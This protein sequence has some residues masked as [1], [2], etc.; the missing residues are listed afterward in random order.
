MPKK[1]RQEKILAKLRRLEK[2]QAPLETNSPGL[3]GTTEIPQVSFQLKTE[4]NSAASVP[5]RVASF[6]YSYVYK[7]LTKSLVFAAVA[8]I[9]QIVLAIFVIK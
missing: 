7:D 8:V 6:D 3:V 2:D 1:T 9:L 4:T 5:T